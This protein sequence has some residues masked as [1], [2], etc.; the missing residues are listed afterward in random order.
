MLYWNANFQ[1]PNSGIQVADIFAIVDESST[2]N[3]LVVKFYAEETKITM[4]FQKEY[5]ASNVTNPYEYLLTL[6][7]FK[8]FKMIKA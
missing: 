8:K 6:D 1:I 3:I 5:I 2:A 4:L 7:D